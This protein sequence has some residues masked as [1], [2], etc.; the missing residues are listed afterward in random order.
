MHARLALALLLSIAAAAAQTAGQT[1]SQLAGQPLQLACGQIKA[2]TQDPSV[3]SAHWGIQVTTLDGTPLCSSNEAQLFR[4]AS[5]NKIFTTAAA[6]A[7]LGPDYIITTRVEAEGEIARGT[8]H[9]DLFLIGAGDDNFGSH[10]IPYVPP[11]QRP[12]VAPPEPATIADIEDLAAQV[13]AT[14]VRTIDGNIV[15]DDRYFKWEPYPSDWSI[16]DVLFGYG[17]PV[18][19]LTIHDNAIDV[20]VGPAP[21]TGKSYSH[22]AIA[23]LTPEVPYY[24][25]QKHLQLLGVDTSESCD[26]RIHYRRDIGSKILSIAGDISPNVAPCHQ[27]VAIQDPAEYAALALKL[28]LERRGVRITGAPVA[29]HYTSLYPS[30]R[31]YRDGDLES[32]F[33]HVQW[34]PPTCTVEQTA[35]QVA[36]PQ[37][38]RTVLASHVSPALLADLAYTNKVSQNL[39]AELLLRTLGASWAC[40]R[41][42]RDGLHIIRQYMLHAGLDPHD[43]VLNDGSGLSSHDLIAPRATAKFLSFAATQPWFAQWKATLPEAGVDGTLGARLKDLPAGRIFA[44]TGTLGE[45]RAL[46]G[47]LVSA[48]GQTLIFSIMVDNH[49]PGT[50]ADRTIM[51]RIVEALAAQD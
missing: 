31:F 28:A 47:Y 22:E 27:A 7:L 46:S 32:L 14:G 33:Q 37:P 11:A 50:G 20:S 2:L 49:L 42:Q 18:S 15:G 40:G 41:S 25:L 39:H 24:T 51:D 38:K 30:G 34:G 44:K 19:A 10:D 6:L 45:S 23:S 13:V 16:D 36:G 21:R 17:A 1:S 35:D 3:A 4:P 8:L 9:G 29:R 43:F 48:S 26:D 12:K 5:N